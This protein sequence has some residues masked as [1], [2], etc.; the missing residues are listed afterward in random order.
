MRSITVASSLKD[1][2]TVRLGNMVVLGG[3]GGGVTPP[4]VGPRLSDCFFAVGLSEYRISDWRILEILGLSDIGSRPQS[5]GQ[6]DIGHTK[7]YR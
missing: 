5:I 4:T 2:S 1:I 3:G 6:S 7:S